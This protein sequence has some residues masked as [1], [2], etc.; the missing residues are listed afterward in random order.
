MDDHQR[1]AA[2]GVLLHAAEEI[3]KG[4]PDGWRRALVREYA[5]PHGRGGTGSWYETEGDGDSLSPSLDVRKLYE[6]VG[7][8]EEVAVELLVEPSG[9]FE[10][11]VGRSLTRSRYERDRVL[12]V[13]R[14]DVLPEQ[15][16]ALEP[17]C[18][19]PTFAGDPDEAVRLFREYL[20]K[21]REIL[22]EEEWLAEP[23]TEDERAALL[24]RFDGELPPDLLALYGEADGDEDTG[25]FHNHP[26][27]ALESTT[28]VEHEEPWSW[29][30]NPLWSTPGGTPPGV[31]RR[32]VGTPKW[33]P[34]ATSTGGDF[35]AVD[36]DPGPAGR[37]GQVIRMGR[38]YGGAPM[39]VAPSV[40]HMLRA[41][42]AALDRGAYR[43]D[44]GYLHVD[45]EF[46]S[47]LDPSKSFW[48]GNAPIPAKPKRIRHLV[49]DK[50]RDVDLSPVRNAPHL[51]AV[52]LFGDGPADLA[53]L[54]DAPVEMLQA[55]L[56]AVDLAPLAGH[57]ALRA[58]RLKTSEPV[59]L[60]VLRTLPRLQAL[61]LSGSAVRDLGVLRELDGLLSLTL[62]PEQWREV[63][64]VPGLSAAELAGDPA[65][66]QI[67]E[68]AEGFRPDEPLDA[69]EYFEGSVR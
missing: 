54:R 14:P 43:N 36:M 13:L 37:P 9:R 25:L 69:P 38:N 51:H 23:L 22:E 7:G 39:L 27:F 17:P 28:L 29:G 53:P 18:A 46:P 10:A 62:S 21:R 45:A 65:P 5:T 42:V 16:G 58:V 66:G 6:L 8:G 11:V 44:E 52:T 19:N 33:V 68:W 40:T 35:L 59:D 15:P 2:H 24:D 55:E 12:Y 1:E 34:F 3:M 60:G 48:R 30:M 61:D 67:R 31:V 56:G 50:V 63:G 4:A 26:W 64:A 32:W 49:V 57:P 47:Y 20:R 41:L